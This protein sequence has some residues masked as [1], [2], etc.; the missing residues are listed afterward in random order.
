MEYPIR[1]ALAQAAPAIPH[2]PDWWYEPKFDGHRTILRRTDDTVI[3]YARSGRVVTSQWMD[4]AVAGMQL[5]PGTA[6]DGEA[7]IWKNGR[8]DFASA[9][10]RAASS[11]TRARALAA[12][13]P[14]SYATWDILEHPQRGQTTGLPY[15]QRRQLLVDLLHDIPPP[16]QA[17]PTTDDRDVAIA[18][19][20]GLQ[21]QGIEGIVCK[22][23]TAGYPMN[24]RGW[25][26][27]R[28]A[29]TEDALVVGYLGPRRRPHRLALAVGDEGG[30]IRLSARL[31]PLLA[32]RIAEVLTAAEAIGERRAEGETYTRVDGYLTV[33]VLAG[34]G[35]HGTLTVTRMR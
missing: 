35:R 33:E 21:E 6:L 16:I 9:Q 34:S 23:G 12:Q 11:I 1:P 26:K 5:P 32:G 14:A 29:D 31:D 17:V 27:V 28:H 19:Y 10:S 3:L 30:P 4:L 25:L 15:T 18:W 2:G 7:V 22:K 8:I 13:H 20:D 24:R